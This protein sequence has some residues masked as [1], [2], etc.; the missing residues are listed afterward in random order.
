MINETIMA[1]LCSIDRDLLARKEIAIE[2]EAVCN[3]ESQ[4]TDRQ[5][6]R[7]REGEREVHTI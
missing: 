6:D 2:I 5:I 3:S 4:T 1:F 7:E